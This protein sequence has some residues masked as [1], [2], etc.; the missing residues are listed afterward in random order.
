[1]AA[2]ND[3]VMRALLDQVDRI[4]RRQRIT[5]WAMFCA[6]VALLVWIGYIGERPQT[7]VKEVVVWSVITT[8]F[9][10]VYGAMALAIYINGQVR[11]ILKAIEIRQ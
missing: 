4:R 6:L 5:F 10:V 1:M 9:A 11:R 3:A 7:D 8:V 2:G